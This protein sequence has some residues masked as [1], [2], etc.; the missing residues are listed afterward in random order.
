MSDSYD[1]KTVQQPND[2]DRFFIESGINRFGER[3]KLA[4]E[5]KGINSNV[6]MGDLCGWS[7]TVI[8]NYLIG[9][10]YPTIERLAT[11]A[12]VLECSPVWLLTGAAPEPD[13]TKLDP[14]QKTEIL[15][16]K[17]E[18]SGVLSM[19]STTQ[20]D[21]LSKAIISHGV[22]GIMSAIGSTTS[23]NDF[24]QLPENERERVLR[25]YNQI[26]EGGAEAC[27]VTQMTASSGDSKKAG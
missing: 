9:K 19:L 27:D 1:E 20:M 13:K 11:L 26:K 16:N 7:D 8:R 3:L 6:K 18:A 2:R 14:E 21:L 15:H 10:T 22:S 5:V 25:L 24:M 4:M 12:Y 23:M 17:V